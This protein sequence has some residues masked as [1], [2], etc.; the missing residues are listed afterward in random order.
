MESESL[1]F[2]NRNF[3]LLMTEQIDAYPMVNHTTEI[4]ASYHPEKYGYD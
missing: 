4:N 3:Y 1:V 2:S